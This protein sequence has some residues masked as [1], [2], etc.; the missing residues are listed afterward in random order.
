M[1]VGKKIVLLLLSTEKSVLCTA[2]SLWN[3]FGSMVRSV[4]HPNPRDEESRRQYDLISHFS[5]V[6]GALY[7]PEG[8][9]HCYAAFAF[10]ESIFDS[11]VANVDD[12]DLRKLFPILQT[13]RYDVPYICR[14]VAEELIH[15]GIPLQ[16]L[17]SFATDSVDAYTIERALGEDRSLINERLVDLCSLIRT[18]YQA[19]LIQCDGVKCSLRADRRKL[20]DKLKTGEYNGPIII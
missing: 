1:F 3:A 7:P 2:S 12:N 6:D 20:F 5:I 15:S 14:L 4:W 8:F 11:I 9:D 18:A 16:D 10:I 19:A 17:S 13:G